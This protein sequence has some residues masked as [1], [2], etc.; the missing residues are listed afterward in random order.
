MSVVLSR[1]PHRGL[2]SIQPKGGH[3]REA[4]GKLGVT[5]DPMLLAV[6]GRLAAVFFVGV[7]VL[8]AYS[9]YYL[10]FRLGK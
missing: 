9:I 10:I 6:S 4:E 5:I 1:S 2:G 3:Q 7:F 8:V